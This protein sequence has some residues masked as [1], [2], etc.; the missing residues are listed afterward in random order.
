MCRSSLSR[1]PYPRVV[2]RILVRIV[3]GCS[4]ITL[5]VSHQ[6]FLITRYFERACPGDGIE[7]T[8]GRRADLIDDSTLREHTLV[9]RAVDRNNRHAWL[10]ASY[11]RD[12]DSVILAA[13]V[14]RV[15]G[16]RTAW[17]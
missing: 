5:S 17:Y 10:H 7:A 15:A 13:G 6:N 3:H 11:R 12:P 2:S 1:H 9:V 14:A 16:A 4:L 8:D